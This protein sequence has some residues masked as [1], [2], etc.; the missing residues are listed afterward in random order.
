MADFV[1]KWG[2]LPSGAFI[3]ELSELCNIF[4]DP[5]RIVAGSFFGW[6]FDLAVKPNEMPGEFI[7]AMVFTHARS[8]HNVQDDIARHFQN[9]T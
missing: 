7:A 2:G 6:C 4:V 1:R 3:E 5:S 8:G 9:M